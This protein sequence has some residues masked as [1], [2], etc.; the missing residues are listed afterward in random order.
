MVK[1]FENVDQTAKNVPLY[2]RG[3]FTIRQK[4][5]KTKSVV[6]GVKKSCYN[7]FGSKTQVGTSKSAKR[8]E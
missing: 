2:G 6:D 7:N 3:Y 1:L 4:M 8:L 5:S